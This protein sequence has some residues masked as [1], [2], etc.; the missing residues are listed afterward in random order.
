[1]IVFYMIGWTRTA[2]ASIILLWRRI[3]KD[4]YHKSTYKLSKRRQRRRT[5]TEEDMIIR[6]SD[7]IVPRMW[8]PLWTSPVK[9]GILYQSIID[10]LIS[11]IVHL[12][13][14]T[15]WSMTIAL[16]FSYTS[17]AQNKTSRWSAVHNRSSSKQDKSTEDK[18]T[19]NTISPNK[20]LSFV[21]IC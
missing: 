15:K 2:V 21:V 9:S 11:M 5:Q 1:M 13:S 16:S 10:N 19:R 4:Q 7:H 18:E 8:H 20:Y 6:K 3:K 17:N 14:Y 12:M